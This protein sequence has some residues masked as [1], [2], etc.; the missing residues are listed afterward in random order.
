MCPHTHVQLC[1]CRA[2][3]QAANGTAGDGGAIWKEVRC[4]GHEGNGAASLQ[5]CLKDVMP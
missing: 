1:L 2:V 5:A 4:Q 3:I